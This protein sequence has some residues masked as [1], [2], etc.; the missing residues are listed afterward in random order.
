MRCSQGYRVLR[1][2]GLQPRCFVVSVFYCESQ[3]LP[4][5][6]C[7]LSFSSEVPSAGATELFP[8]RGE[9][10]ARFCECLCCPHLPAGFQNAAEPQGQGTALPQNSDSGSDSDTVMSPCAPLNLRTGRG[11]EDAHSPDSTRYVIGS[12]PVGS[13]L[14]SRLKMPDRHQPLTHLAVDSGRAQEGGRKG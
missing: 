8:I 2:A 9:P 5:K 1:R 14:E 4:A 6:S 3:V 11:P 12:G 13:N 7:C 10:G